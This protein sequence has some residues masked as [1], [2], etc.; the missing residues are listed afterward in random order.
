MRKKKIIVFA[1]IGAC[2][3]AAGFLFA[4]RNKVHLDCL[5][6]LNLDDY[7]FMDDEEGRDE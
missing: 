5:K 1:V 6:N 2:A 3:A 4:R 7:E